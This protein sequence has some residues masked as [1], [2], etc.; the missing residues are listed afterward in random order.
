MVE[1]SAT[2]MQYFKAYD[3]VIGQHVSTQL[4]GLIGHG[5][6]FLKHWLNIDNL[7]SNYE[8]NGFCLCIMNQM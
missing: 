5:L 3:F 2:N 6:I 7:V 8:F 1:T 4:F